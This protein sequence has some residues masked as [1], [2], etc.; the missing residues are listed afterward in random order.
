MKSYLSLIPISAKVRRRQNRMTLLCIIFSVFLVTAIFSMA[1]M[2]VRME[3]TRTKEVH[4]NWHIRIKNLSEEAAAQIAAR[5][6]VA[7]AS[8]YDAVNLEMD[9]KY[10]INGKQ[11]ALCGVEEPFRTEIMSYFPD[12]SPLGNDGVVLT[13]NA[14][15]L[16]GVEAGSP[17]TLKTPGGSY[18]LRVFGFRS[19]DLK[20][21]DS[22]TGETT[23]L[24]MQEKQVGAF[25]DISVLRRILTENGDKGSPV[26]FVQFRT[27]ANVK[28][29]V[30]EIQEQSGISSRDLEQ[31]TLVM[32]LMGL[33]DNPTIRNLYP[34]AVV[35][36]LL[37]LLAGALMISGTLNSTIAQRSQFFG[38]MRCIGMS[39]RQIIRFVRLEALNWCKTAIPA[40]VLLGTVVS[41]AS[42][43]VMRYGVGGEFADM[44][45]FGVSA[46]GIASGAV[47]GV[48]TVVLAA[49]SPAKRAAKVSPAAAVS[50]SLDNTQSIRR[51][52]KA[53]F[54]RIETALGISHAVA[55]KKNLFLMA[56]SFALSIL[57]FLCFSVMV[58]LLNYMFPV[59]SAAPDLSIQSDDYTNTVDHALLSQIRE[60]PGVKQAFGRMSSPDIPAKFSIETEQTTVDLISYDDFELDCLAKDDSLRPGSDLASVYGDNG[61]ALVI[62]DPDV[63]LGIGDRAELLG[64]RVEVSGVLKFNPFSNDG[65]TNGEIIL[66]CSEQIFARLTKETDF[67]IIDIQMEKDAGDAE[68]EAIR[69]LVKGT[70]TFRDRREEG[71]RSL[72]WAFGLFTY[73]FL[74][75][76]ALITMLNIVNSISMSVSAR[77]RQ[78]GAMR[79]VGMNGRQLS[80]MIAIEAATYAF[81]GCVS[82][83]AIG[84]PLNR[85]IYEKLITAHFPYYT[86]SIPTRSLLVILLFVLAAT[87]VSVYAPSKRIQNMAVT[88]TINE[89]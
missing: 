89:F 16:L 14:R 1:D 19:S 86:W 28:K 13:P 3:S 18:P 37:I 79:A 49:Q 57:L 5:E 56:G 30:A 53:G 6:D 71:D 59:K 83:C 85:L 68:A 46:V 51:R 55:A 50:G 87:A 27:H 36:F 43:A 60:M 22:N 42:C 2:L 70:Y 81:A 40:G 66:I 21:E 38:M 77:T 75:I 39:R 33:S 10:F 24:L 62:W 34:V 47:L 67:G 88:E 41:W 32:A 12:S 11:A 69:N 72:Y 29:A 35:L 9:R 31:N 82:G 78:Y 84:L 80:R 23:A 54:L 15:E 4:G 58:Q 48:L 20:Y 64:S 45:V 8:W 44:P 76:I 65:G 7:A 73:G 25:L 26:Y 61:K 17:I 74:I 63:S 52:A